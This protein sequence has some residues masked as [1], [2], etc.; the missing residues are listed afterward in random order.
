[1]RLLFSGFVIFRAKKIDGKPLTRNCKELPHLF[2]YTFR[3]DLSKQTYHTVFKAH[4]SQHRSETLSFIGQSK[5]FTFIS[6]SSSRHDD[7]LAAYVKRLN[8]NSSCCWLDLLQRTETTCSAVL[9]SIEC[10]KTVWA[11]STLTTE[12]C[13][14][15]L[16]EPISPCGAVSSLCF[17]LVVDDK[18][19]NTKVLHRG[20]V[21]K[22]Q[23]TSA[24]TLNFIAFHSRWKN[25]IVSFSV[26]FW[27]SYL[28]VLPC[29]YFGPVVVT[30]FSNFRL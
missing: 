4:N 5:T 6:I 16:S 30:S 27:S 2:F 18:R 29:F 20:I 24:C 11:Q 13:S 23:F 1:M 3:V 22:H 21:N 7:E 15:G 26:L 10:D 17:C 28:Y 25:H 9:L 8:E 19:W 14:I 12:K